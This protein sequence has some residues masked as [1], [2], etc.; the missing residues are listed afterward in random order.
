MNE[1]ERDALMKDVV[2]AMNDSGCVAVGVMDYWTFD[3]VKAIRAYLR[4]PDALQLTPTLFPGIELRMVSPGSFRLN[5]HV[6]LNPRLT[7]DQLDAFKAQLRIANFDRPLVDANLV[8]F[9]KTRISNER[10]AELSLSRERVQGS[11]VDALIAASKTIEVTPESVK[12]A[13]KAFGTDAILMIPFDT[14]DG[15][16]KIHFREH[17]NFP[18]ELLA[19][20]AIFEVSTLK[21]RDAFVGIR[22]QENETFFDAF[23]SA[24]GQA[25]L[26]VR[27]SDA[28]RL[29]DYGKSPND[30]Y[31]W[32]KAEPSFSGLLQACKEPANRSYIGLEPPKLEFVRRNPHL[33]VSGVDIR[34][35][36]GSKEADL[37]FDGT[38]LEFNEDLVAIIGRKGSGKSALADV[39]GFL[40]DTPNGRYFS[41]LSPTR[42]RLPRDN[43][44]ASFEGRLNW[45]QGAGTGEFRSLS[46]GTSTAAVERVKYLPQRYFEELCNDHVEG[47]DDL[48][49]KELQKVIFSHL[50]PVDKENGK[51]LDE[52]IEIRSSVLQDR[53]RR[54][55]KEI[56]K[57]N[58]RIAML[59]TRA[60]HDR[61]THL[62]SELDLLLEK[63]RVL[64]EHQPKVQLP[65]TSDDPGIAQLNEAI[66]KAEGELRAVDNVIAE[67]RKEQDAARLKLRRISEVRARVSALRETI[68]DARRQMHDALSEIGVDFDQLIQFN[69]DLAGLD[70]VEAGVKTTLTD[71]GRALSPDGEDSLIVSRLRPDKTLSE[72]KARLDEPNRRYQQELSSHEEWKQN[73]LELLGDADTPGTFWSVWWELEALPSLD[74]ELTALRTARTTTAKEILSDIQQMAAVRATLYRPVQELV[75]SDSDIRTHLHV[76]FSVNLSFDSFATGIFDFVKQSAGSFVGYE[77]SKA[78]VSRMLSA[79]D[80]GTEAG[81]ENFFAE[82]ETALSTDVRNA[83]KRPVN[84]DNVLRSDK[85]SEQ[86]FDFIYQLEYAQLTYGL[87]MGGVSL[88]R[89][90]PGQRGALLLIFYLLVDRDRIPIVLDQPEENLDNETVFRLLVNV[91]NKAKQHRQV[92]MITH[93]AN[94]AVACDAEQIVCCEMN[95]DDGNRIT[96]R[97]GAIEEHPM[98]KIVVDVLEGTKR[99]FDNRS[100]KYA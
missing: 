43:K 27:G 6:L 10:L 55:R 58:G 14:N 95:R 96:Y 65:P 62:R 92:I 42:F 59:S 67:K 60:G 31:T 9:G 45:A 98:N 97:S 33:F 47:K 28:H 99:A 82:V 15:M 61:A 69:V 64:K 83:D 50:S 2:T 34:K 23:Q 63:I 100:R 71:A 1:T 80:L 57:L 12:E 32:I 70:T 29:A 73:W 5:M 20:E 17:Y 22:T 68:E 16:S 26:A 39:I 86:L 56:E 7:D 19:M 4:K 85:K 46:S 38:N 54:N 75:D 24:L 40:G 94:L 91:I 48:L 52:L 53:L 18:R 41:F 13:L 89:L 8:E 49:Q 88:E 25:K 76:E 84:L 72:L 78:L 36:A 37:W 3:G 87:R 79:N 21:T 74:G 51:S 11:D 77:E 81:L 44:A 30:K 66:S 35:I 93:N 90:S